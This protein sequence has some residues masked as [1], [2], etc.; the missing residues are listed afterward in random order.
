MVGG[1]NAEPKRIAVAL[2]GGV[3][4]AV[5][6]ALLRRDGYEV[7]A[8]FARGWSPKE[9]R[10]D[11]AAEERDAMRVAARLGV[12]FRSV[13]LGE[14]YEREVVAPLLDGYRRGR[15]VNP[16][17][18]CNKAVK[19]GALLAAARAEGF[20][21]LATG[22]YA[23]R[24]DAGGEARL[25]RG[26]DAA[27]DQSYFLWALNQDELKA[28]RFPVG[29]LAKTE[30]RSIARSLDLPVA[31]KPDSQG[32]C[33]VGE[34]DFKEF[35]RARLSPEPGEAVDRQGRTVG[36]HDGAIL[37][38]P[39][40][41]IALAGDGAAPRGQPWYVLAQDVATNRLTVGSAPVAPTGPIE[42]MLDHVSETSPGAFARAETCQFRYRSHPV[43]LLNLSGRA[44]RVAAPDFAPAPG[45]SAVFYAADG[46]CLGGGEIVAWSTA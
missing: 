22:H 16:D 6:A 31:E 46:E 18:W 30:V 42:I 43:K 25:C 11:W 44:A 7:A 5:A 15:A 12:P 45:Q 28:A 36:A 4:S 14:A 1:V 23:R 19:F 37:Y 40:E 39:G 29:N 9:S 17:V 33:F 10:C 8:F 24:V 35:L 34:M 2:S 3:D 32:V 26:A 27:K 41:R 13:D 38:V 20:A 21:E